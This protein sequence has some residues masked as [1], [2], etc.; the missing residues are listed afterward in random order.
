MTPFLADVTQQ[1]RPAR[2]GFDEYDVTVASPE[3]PCGVTWLA[4]CLLEIGVSLWKPWGIDDR[5]HWHLARN[6]LWRY[7]CAH[8]PWSRLIPGLVDGREV[9]FRPS[10]VPRYT[11]A[12]PGQLPATRKL[13]LFVRDPRDSLYSDWRR[14]QHVAGDAAQGL[15][16]EQYLAKPTIGLGVPPAEWLGL[17][18][19]SWQVAAR[20]TASLVVRFEDAKQFPERTL[21]KVLGFIGLDVPA[22]TVRRAVLASHHARVQAAEEC[23]VRHGIVASRLLG[24]GTAFEYR[25]HPERPKIPLGSLLAAA[26]LRNGYQVRVADQVEALDSGVCDALLRVLRPNCVDAG[27]LEHCLR[28]AASSEGRAAC[29]S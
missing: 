2:E 24:P 20:D 12:W 14:R 5:E 3:L 6:R 16:L 10:P 27:F 22:R 17:H 26:A 19:R 25:R 9:R 28:E 15:D 13:I 23:L 7:Q 21:R 8:S 11:H 29:P 1:Y 18:W 4:S